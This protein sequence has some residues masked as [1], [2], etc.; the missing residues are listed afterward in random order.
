MVANAMCWSSLHWNISLSF[1]SFSYNGVC[2]DVSKLSVCDVIVSQKG[3]NGNRKLQLL[4][5][6]YNF[7]RSQCAKIHLWAKILLSKHA[8]KNEPK[9]IHFIGWKG[10]KKYLKQPNGDYCWKTQFLGIIYLLLSTKARWRHI[11]TIEY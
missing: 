5:W 11:K 7:T 1:C 8:M 2:Y 9:E 10:H 6:V 3:S 4:G